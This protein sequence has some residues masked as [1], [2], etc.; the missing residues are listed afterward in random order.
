MLDTIRTRLNTAPK[1][2]SLPLGVIVLLGIV[3]WAMHRADATD[4]YPQPDVTLICAECGYSE[5]L[6]VRQYARQSEE[7]LP[8]GIALIQGPAL[9]CPDCGQRCLERPQSPDR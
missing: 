3:W 1:I 7:E 9:T 8:G 4:D 5:Q 2:V 6:T